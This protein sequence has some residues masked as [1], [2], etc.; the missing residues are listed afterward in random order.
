MPP[1]LSALTFY[2]E[3]AI[4]N[5]DKFDEIERRMMKMERV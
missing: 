1:H 5:V 3:D 2:T 4:I